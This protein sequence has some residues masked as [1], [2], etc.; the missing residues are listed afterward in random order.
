MHDLQRNLFDL[1]VQNVLQLVHLRAQGAGYSEYGNT[2]STS[3][4]KM[5]QQPQNDGTQRACTHLTELLHAKRRLELDVVD[6]NLGFPLLHLTLRGLSH[7][8]LQLLI[9][10]MH[11]LKR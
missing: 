10:Q 11:T 4:A 2:R 7:F 8:R 6:D 5:V 1:A 9:Q 3:H